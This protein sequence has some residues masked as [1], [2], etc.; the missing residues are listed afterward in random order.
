[1][2]QLKNGFAVQVLLYNV[3]AWVLLPL[4]I[5]HAQ[6]T[7]DGSLGPKGPLSG[8]NFTID[9]KVGRQVGSNLFHSFSEF[10]IQT[11][12]SATFT[13]PDAIRNV[14]G[15]VTGGQVSEIDGTL[16][17][18]MPNAALY[19]LNPA[20]VMFGPKAKLDVP[21]S[22]HV[23]TADYLKL[24]DGGRF[25]AT[26]PET[27][28]L[29]SA[30]PQAF[31]FLGPNPA[32]IT[33][34]GSTLQVAK[35]QTL[36]IVGGDVTMTGGKVSAPEGQATIVSTGS[37]GEVSVPTVATTEP[38]TLNGFT[39]MG[40]LELKQGAV[41][42]GSGEGGGG[43]ELSGG[44]ITLQDGSALVSERQ[45]TKA[46]RTIRVHGTESITLMDHSLHDFPSSE[47]DANSG[48][49]GAA[50]EII[51]QAPQVMVNH[52]F[53]SGGNLEVS[54]QQIDLVNH[55]SI[56]SWGSSTVTVRATERVTIGSSG[57]ILCVLGDNGNALV[58][59]P[60]VTIDDGSIFA[61]TG[62]R[63]NLEISGQQVDIINDSEITS[64]SFDAADAATVTVRGTEGVTLSAS[65]I[66]IS[67]LGSEGGAAGTVTVQ[68][69]RVRI[70]KGRIS[71]ET[72]TLMLCGADLRGSGC[73]SP[74]LDGGRGGRV[75][76]KGQQVEVINHSTIT[77]G[78]ITARD[79]GTVTVQGTEGVTLSTSTISSDTSGRGAAGRVT[80]QAPQVLVDEG[81]VIAARALAGS[82][83]QG[84]EV[85]VSGQWVEV[86]NGGTISSATLGVGAAGQVR[87]I[88]D[89]LRIAG[90]DIQ[91]NRSRIAASTQ[92]AGRGG[93][94]NIQAQTLLLDAGGEISATS[95]GTGDAGT[96]AICVADELRMTDGRISTQAQQAGG[97]NITV[98][99]GGVLDMVRSELTTTVPNGKGNAG[100][101]AVT[102]QAVALNNSTVRAQAADGNG[103]NIRIKAGA[104]LASPDSEVTASSQK[105]VSGTVDIQGVISDLSGSLKPL[106][107]EYQP[108]VTLVANRC[109]G[110]IREGT[111]NSFV[112]TGRGGVP[113]PPGGLLSSASLVAEQQE[114]TGKAET[115]QDFRLTEQDLSAAW[116]AVDDVCAW[117][118][119]Q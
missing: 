75:E 12:Q 106:S 53:I 51:V 55:S 29:T 34:Q 76:V 96:V 30:P 78:S 58:Q 9:A 80:V 79:A 33:I 98:Q 46:G 111:V 57:N 61:I 42:D 83:G 108:A 97:G 52:A 47:I 35:A 19:L 63:G 26:Q 74:P 48:G 87:V 90:Q 2:R 71:A 104:Y 64:E 7:L 101:I 107:Q 1:M 14:I 62:K 119:G 41:I 25:A 23:S 16:R 116:V 20:G 4:T 72:G 66:S 67:N 69:P 49:T 36:S 95:A 68:A 91:G 8:P 89:T 115:R 102:A 114:K 112:V 94:V 5:S 117:P 118:G 92:T 13:G 28:V 37:A 6:I 56:Q 15:R 27:S 100:N 70:N 43:I 113:L 73:S 88:A 82:K 110:R 50:G 81:G 10:N 105:G 77:S 93:D 45:G 39:R 38:V 99:V 40:K 103:G 21:G 59:A 22:F 86:I 11:D 18:T 85:E 84:G 31:G 65:T 32:P 44:K 24:S 60:H 109:A 17:S 3:L 54:G